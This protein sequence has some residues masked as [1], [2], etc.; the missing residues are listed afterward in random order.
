MKG[1]LIA[2]EARDA[3]LTLCEQFAHKEREGNVVAIPLDELRRIA[4]SEKQMYQA[5]VLC[6]D[7]TK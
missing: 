1:A 5:E 2:R 7:K 3:L 6:L 4:R